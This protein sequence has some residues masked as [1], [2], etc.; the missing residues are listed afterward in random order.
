A[1]LVVE[2]ARLHGY[3]R[4]PE[5]LPGGAAQVGG[6]REPLPLLDRV[7]DVLAAHGLL[8]CMTYSFQSAATADRLRWQAEDPRRQ[9]V[10]LRNPLSEE[11]AVMRTSLMG[12]LL[13]TAARN[14]A[15]GAR[16]VHLFE[17]GAVYHPKSL[18]LT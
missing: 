9:A 14:R 1:D 15:R 5:A 11:L 8:E 7:R 4:L 6:Q 3:D 16:E 2:V 10:V 18:P 13:E 17:I 12:G